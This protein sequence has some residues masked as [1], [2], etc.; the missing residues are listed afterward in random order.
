MIL[1]DCSKIYWVKVS[2]RN[3]LLPN[4]NFW[5]KMIDDKLKESRS[6][7]P[8]GID[9]FVW[10]LDIISKATNMIKKLEWKK[11]RTLKERFINSW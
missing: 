3:M 10:L 4:E 1:V 6:V 7:F 5:E 11:H 2:F 8:T 9:S